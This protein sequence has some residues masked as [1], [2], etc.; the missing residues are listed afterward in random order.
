MI[1]SGGIVGFDRVFVLG[2]SSGG[3][4]AQLAVSL[5]G[6]SVKLAPLRVR[7]YVLMAPFFGGVEWTKSERKRREQL[8]TLDV[9]ER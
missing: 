8:M 6:G 3:T 5:G 4:T 7:G 2:K 1:E 9:V